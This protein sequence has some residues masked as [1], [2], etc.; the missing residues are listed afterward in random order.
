MFG[1]DCLSTVSYGANRQQNFCSRIK[2]KCFYQRALN[3]QN[4]L[5]TVLG[6]VTQGVKGKRNE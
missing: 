2:E 5:V 3:A 6:N 1:D 4:A